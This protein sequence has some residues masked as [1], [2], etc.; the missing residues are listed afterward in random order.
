MEE[1][2]QREA[3]SEGDQNAV[4]L[5][6]E[7]RG[8]SD[9]PFEMIYRDI[10]IKDSKKQEQDI[11]SPICSHNSCLT[12]DRGS[13]HCVDL[14]RN[15]I[16]ELGVKMYEFT[17][18]LTLDISR[19]RLCSIARGISALVHL[20]Q[21]FLLGNKLKMSSIPV[22]ELVSMKQLSIIDLRCKFLPS[23]VSYSNLN[24]F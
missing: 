13:L 2:C 20:E 16:T 5:S 22:D 14:K 15:R 19:N 17:S 4:L 3:R 23:T 10:E 7:S 6:Y 21:L 8:L 1:S 11:Q 24:Q 12:K 18:L 9:V